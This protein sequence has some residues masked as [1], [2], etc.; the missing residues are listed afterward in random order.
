MREIVDAGDESCE[1]TETSPEALTPDENSELG[2]GM[3]SPAQNI[4]D[5]W[6]DFGNTFRL[7]QVF[8][9]R[10]NPLMKIIHVPT[11]QLHVAQ[12]MSGSHDVPRNIEAL[13]F[14]TFLMAVVALSPEECP[15][16][17]GCSREAALLRFSTGTRLSLL[18]LDFHRSNDLPTLQA[19]VLYMVG[20]PEKTEAASAGLT[21]PRN[22]CSAATTGTRPG[23]S[24]ESWSASRRRWA[25]TAMA[26]C[27]AWDHSR[28][29]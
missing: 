18:R 2:L 28:P 24:T 8:V 23:S 13:L 14:S 7:W 26:S 10:V 4:E 25:C 15:A 3:D 27:W 17:L 6:P 12:A 11:L 9:E 21:A 22:P 20:Q 19:L 29:R 1:G 16:Q 5:L